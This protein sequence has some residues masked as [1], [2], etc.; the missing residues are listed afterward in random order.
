MMLITIKSS[1]DM[2][3]NRDEKRYSMERKKNCSDSLFTNSNYLTGAATVFDISGTFFDY[4]TSNTGEEAD[5]KALKCDF[6]MVGQDLK[7]AMKN[8]E[9]EY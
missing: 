7:S 8:F 2:L 4:N 6:N 9:L 3:F 5:I 1:F